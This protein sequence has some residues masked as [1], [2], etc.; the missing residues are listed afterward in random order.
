[1][2]LLFASF[3][4]RDPVVVTT[5]A[6]ATVALTAVMLACSRRRG[7]VFVLL[8]LGTAASLALIISFTG[9]P[10]AGGI[11]GLDPS[12]WGPRRVVQELGGSALGLGAWQHGTD[13]PLNVLLYAPA[14]LTL[15]ARTPRLRK[16]WLVTPGLAALS[17]LTEIWQALTGTRSGQV[18]DIVT[19]TIGAV[20]GVLVMLTIRTTIGR[21]QPMGVTAITSQTTRRKRRERNAIEF[22]QV[23]RRAAPLPLPRTPRR[24]VQTTAVSEPCSG[25][26]K[27]RARPV[28]GGLSGWITTWGRDRR[29]WSRAR[30]RQVLQGG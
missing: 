29:G 17:L 25:D 28:T 6:L 9:L 4:L 15:A 7:R 19:N 5:F 14:G 12:L 8:V 18:S 11:A 13:G 1:M 2:V 24:L 16:I 30:C 27:R 10:S 21:L 26:A 22:G 23:H 3:V 20:V